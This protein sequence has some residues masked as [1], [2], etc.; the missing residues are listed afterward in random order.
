MGIINQFDEN[1]RRN[2][3]KTFP[4]GFLLYHAEKPT[5]GRSGI[6]K[7]VVDF[8]IWFANALKNTTPERLFRRHWFKFANTA[9]D[10]AQHP[11][12]Q[13]KDS[14]KNIA[15]SLLLVQNIDMCPQF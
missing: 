15:F 4:L 3:T 8:G 1:P 13:K 2:F 9:C 11:P 12:L 5:D 7:L 14:C 10:L 6:T